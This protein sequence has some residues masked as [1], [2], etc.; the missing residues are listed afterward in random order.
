MPVVT[1]DPS[2]V[3]GLTLPGIQIPTPPEVHLWVARLGDFVGKDGDLLDTLPR[4]ERIRAT[5]YRF[6]EPRQ[7]FVV[8]RSLLRVL[9]SHYAGIPASELQIDAGVHGRPYLAG[10]RGTGLCFNMAHGGELIAIAVACGREVGVDI[11]TF[12]RAVAMHA[13]MRRLY[14]STELQ[15]LARQPPR[16]RDGAMLTL[17]TCKEA[18]GKALGVGLLPP[19]LRLDDVLSTCATVNDLPQTWIHRDCARAWGVHRLSGLDGY[20][21]A[22][23]ADLPTATSAAIELRQYALVAG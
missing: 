17:W 11:E 19:I 21:G 12:D 7:R 9:L 6:V 14:S 18:F 22:L 4:P 10:P 16:T 5:R 2:T 23:V 13:V 20:I 3:L 15:W 1:R 8:A